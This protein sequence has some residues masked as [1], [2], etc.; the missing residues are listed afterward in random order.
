MT[1]LHLSIK[2]LIGIKK[3]LEIFITNIKSDNLEA[4]GP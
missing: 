2:Y 3:S 4:T 1:L